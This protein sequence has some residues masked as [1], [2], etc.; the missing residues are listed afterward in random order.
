MAVQ[1]SNVMMTAA[2]RS[3]IRIVLALAVLLATLV[4]L[5]QG[6]LILRDP[7]LPKLPLTIAV[8]IWGVGGTAALFASANWLVEQFSVD[9]QRRIQPFIFVGPAMLLLGW[10][11]FLP[12]IRT[13]YLSFFGGVEASEFV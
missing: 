7:D 5:W 4:V 1:T 8:I 12:T 10:F 13:L 3:P 2:P 11:L 9:W 6:L